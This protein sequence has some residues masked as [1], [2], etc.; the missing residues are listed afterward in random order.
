MGALRGVR[1]LDLASLAG[2]MILAFFLEH[3]GALCVNLRGLAS[4]LRVLRLRF[5]R[6]HQLR[7][8]I[9]ARVCLLLDF[10]LIGCLLSLVVLC[11]GQIVKLVLAGQRFC[12][13]DLVL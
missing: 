13:T 11:A 3:L 9:A 6:L 10:T 4:S 8:L 2:R 1:A 7:A 5:L 12:R